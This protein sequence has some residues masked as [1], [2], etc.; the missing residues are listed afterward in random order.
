MG[1]AMEPATL[2]SI[3]AQRRAAGAV[4]GSTWMLAP[5]FG[6]SSGMRLY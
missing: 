1:C 4:F 5:Y 6:V 2:I 3:P